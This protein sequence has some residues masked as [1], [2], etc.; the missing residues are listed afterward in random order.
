MPKPD[1]LKD[2][3]GDR[4]QEFG[5]S[6]EEKVDSASNNSDDLPEAVLRAMLLNRGGTSTV[7]PGRLTTPQQ[8]PP[9]AL[10]TIQDG[11]SA[12][13]ALAQPPSALTTTSG[14][15]GLSSASEQLLLRAQFAVNPFSPSSP[16]QPMPPLTGTAAAGTAPAAAAASSN[17]NKRKRGQP[18]NQVAVAGT[19]AA[20]FPGKDRT[21]W[22]D[23]Y[24]QLQAY[25]VT[26]GTANP[27]QT[28]G[29]PPGDY[30]LSCWLNGQRQKF[31]KGTL[32]TDRCEKLRS[33]GCEGFSE[34][35]RG[36]D[37]VIKVE[38]PAKKEKK[39][40][41]S[42]ETRY[43][44]LCEYKKKF[45]HANPPYGK[46]TAEACQHLA[47]WLSNQRSDYRAGKKISPDQV[48]LLR[49]LGCRGFEPEHAGK[50]KSST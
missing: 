27:P 22:E 19:K 30:K 24:A 23:R 17:S 33:L 7:P 10:P 47:Q 21:A 31:R 49:D 40:K 20:A 29:T 3:I 8:A 44:E 5:G 28:R 50:R 9:P 2:E 37:A 39:K 16:Q 12:F 13:G 34:E 43:L 36:V 32:D 46:A 15:S 18:E 4:F 42:W 6:T 11:T 1:R 41:V 38:K 26:H 14:L 45:N 25:K 35:Q 48:Q